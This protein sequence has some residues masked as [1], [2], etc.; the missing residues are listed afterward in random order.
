MLTATGASP[1]AWWQFTTVKG[2][3]YTLHVAMVGKTGTSATATVDVS[4]NGSSVD[5]NTHPIGSTVPLY[6]DFSFTAEG[7]A[8]YVRLSG[9]STN[10]AGDTITF[11]A[12]LVHNPDDQSI[13]P[14]PMPLIPAALLT[15]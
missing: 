8:T 1:L 9:A 10:V 2:V 12:G 3:S 11:S 6:A 7:T 14:P 13:A 5:I 4:T 15:R